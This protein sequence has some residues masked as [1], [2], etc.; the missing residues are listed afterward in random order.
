MNFFKNLFSEKKCA[1][2]N[3]QEKTILCPL[4]GNVIPLSEVNDPVFAQGIL[5]PGI[6]IEPEEDRLY[7][8]VDGVVSAVYPTGHAIGLQSADGMEILIHVGI[9]TVEMKGNGFSNRVKQG[10]KV[11]AGDLLSEIDISKIRGAGYLATTMMLVTNAD[12][13]G[14]LTVEAFGETEALTPVCRFQ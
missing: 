9:N 7:S 13:M 6:G 3:W 1:G 2:S 8:P 5:G 10:Q 4:K 11:K 12:A 14:E